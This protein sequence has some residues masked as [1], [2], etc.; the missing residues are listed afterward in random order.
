MKQVPISGE[1]FSGG[2]TKGVIWISF[3][4]TGIRVIGFLVSVILLRFLSLYEYGTYQLV[5]SI[6]G[7]FALLSFQGLEQ[8]VIAAGA[9]ALGRGDERE[10]I[11]IGQGFFTLRILLGV[12]L[13]FVIS[14][15]SFFLSRWYGG[16]VLHFVRLYAWIFLILPFEKIIS[17]HFSVRRTFKWVSGFLFF[18]E[19]IKLFAILCTFFI[20]HAGTKGVLLSMVFAQGVSCVFVFPFVGRRYM[21]VRW[22]RAL[23]RLWPML[24]MQGFWVIGQRVVR[25]AERNIRP[26]FLQFFIGREA[27]AVFSLAE[28]AYGYLTGLFPID[29]VLMPSIASETDNRARLQR[30]LERGIKYTIPLYGGIAVAFF[31]LAPTLVR[32]V[33][34]NYVPAIP[35]LRVIS[36]YLPFIGV[37][38][39]LTSFY[40]SHFEQKKMFFLLVGRLSFFLVAS[41]FWLMGLG[42][43]GAA[44]EFVVTLLLFNAARLAL[45]FK[46]YPELRIRLRALFSWD[47]YDRAVV[48]R[49][50]LQLR[51]RFSRR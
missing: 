12:L 17:Y 25:E 2:V 10:A 5:L 6:C 46:T 23:L 18:Q 35:L 28:K 7:L 31:L 22:A 40:L 48:Q 4:A 41:P 49:A 11:S 21:T 16:E 24:R 30:I 33:F 51:Q 8:L 29:E 43:L 39:L 34:P 14:V 32:F 44:Y 9:R 50:F 42:V 19:L 27:V 37:A 3:G 38:Y 1:T 20:F 26:L 13:W 15:S 47:A 36:L 45:L